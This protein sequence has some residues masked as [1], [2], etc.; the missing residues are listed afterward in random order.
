MKRSYTAAQLARIN[1]KFDPDTEY[2]LAVRTFLVEAIRATKQYEETQ[3]ELE[4]SLE[5][6][7]NDIPAVIADGGCPHMRLNI[8]SSKAT[9]IARLCVEVKLLKDF[10]GN[11]QGNFIDSECELE[12]AIG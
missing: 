3:A 11:A 9:N 1:F 2:E 7:Q 4:S 10:A 8:V 6:I 5:S 12:V